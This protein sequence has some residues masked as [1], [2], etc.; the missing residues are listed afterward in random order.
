MTSFT[1]EDE[2]FALADKFDENSGT[3]EGLVIPGGDSVFGMITDQTLLVKPVVALSQAPAP[4][5]TT[6]SEGSEGASPTPGVSPGGTDPAAP[7]SASGAIF[8]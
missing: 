6:G 7:Q 2:G 8:Q 5:K 1:W 4:G 3:Y